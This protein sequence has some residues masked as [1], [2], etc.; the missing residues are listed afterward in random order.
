M[1]FT[2]R[3][4]CILNA[5]ATLEKRKTKKST[6]KGTATKAT[7]AKPCSLNTYNLTENR[8]ICLNKV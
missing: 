1:H 4:C 5:G 3:L 2:S 7:K 6:K 8:F